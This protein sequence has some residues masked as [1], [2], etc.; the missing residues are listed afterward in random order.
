M[1]LALRDFAK[2]L[3][4]GASIELYTM[5]C[6]TKVAS[7]ESLQLPTQLKKSFQADIM[8]QLETLSASDIIKIGAHINSNFKTLE[9]TL[10]EAKENIQSIE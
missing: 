6:L 4:E 5:I 10:E 9:L 1:K 7:M 3:E 8:T 2:L